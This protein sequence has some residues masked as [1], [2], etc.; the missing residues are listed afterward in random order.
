MT[1]ISDMRE[2]YPASWRSYRRTE[3]MERLNKAW[4]KLH[5]SNLYG[6][7]G[8]CCGSCSHYEG[9]TEMK[10]KGLTN[11]SGYVTYNVQSRDAVVAHGEIYLGFGSNS[12][13]SPYKQETDK[14]IE[15]AGNYEDVLVVT[16]GFLA[17]AH[18]ESHGFVV[19]WNGLAGR[20]LKLSLPDGWDLA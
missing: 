8:S 11:L 9:R 12:I 18:F 15:L 6:K 1:L 19:E 13:E 5:K 17:K 14:A 7:R 20:N 16:V 4:R 10:E 2:T 3:F